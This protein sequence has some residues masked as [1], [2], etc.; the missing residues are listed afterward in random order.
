MQTYTPSVGETV[1]ETVLW[2]VA[3]ANEMGETVVAKFND[4]ELTAK[5]GDD[6]NAIAEFY[7]SEM[8]RRSEEYRKSPE[9]QRAEREAEEHR[10]KAQAQMDEAMAELPT[11]DFADFGAMI[12][13]L[14]EVRDPSDYIGVTT[15][16][17]QIVSTFRENGYEPDVNYGQDFDDEDEEN[18]ARWLIGQALSNLELDIHAI[19]QVFH[20]FAD[21][22]RNKFRTVTA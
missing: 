2:I 9:G 13:W 18:F 17:A 20:K 12:A 19:H 16:Y 15:P 11:L 6:A 4:I 21:D 8:A 3:M 22:W 5:P 14:E 10:Q 7:S 1:D